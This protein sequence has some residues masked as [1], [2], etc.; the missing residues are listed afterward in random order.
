MLQENKN[1]YKKV[2]KTKNL[3]GWL[4]FFLMIISIVL[5]SYYFIEVQRPKHIQPESYLFFFLISIIML[6]LLILGLI[7]SI[8]SFPRIKGS[9]LGPILIFLIITIPFILRI[10]LPSLL[11]DNFLKNAEKIKKE[12]VLTGN[13]EEC[14]KIRWLPFLPQPFLNFLFVEEELLQNGKG[15]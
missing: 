10:V 2:K 9:R 7:L 1:L 11:A 6:P 5:M 13:K 14:F 3:K 12:V 15:R 4:G 8:L